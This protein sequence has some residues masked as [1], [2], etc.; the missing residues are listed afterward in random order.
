[1][2][3]VLS[4]FLCISRFKTGA[5]RPTDTLQEFTQNI[6]PVHARRDKIHGRGDTTH[7]GPVPA[8]LFI[9]LQP[10]R[11]QVEGRLFIAQ[12]DLGVYDL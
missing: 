7:S 4:I 5:K 6:R 9:V 2:T 1:M 12:L 10:N 11:K 3:T 8:C